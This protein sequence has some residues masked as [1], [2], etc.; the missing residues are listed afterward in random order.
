MEGQ[1]LFGDEIPV[2]LPREE[3]EEEFRSCCEDDEVWKENEEP[4]KVESKDDLD[5]FSV[6]MFFKGISL[7]GFG[8]SS[9]GLSGIGVV[10]ERAANVPVIQVQKKLDFYV[11]EPVADYLALMDGLVEAVQNK[12][13]RVYA[14]TD[15]ELLYDQVSSS[16]RKS[17]VSSVIIWF[18]LSNLKPTAFLI[19][20]LSAT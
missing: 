16:L 3:D 11:E 9:V 15:S 4:V 12:V 5:E 18:L 1:A 7:T 17:Y 10:M 20:Y 2:N 6:K 8:D 13:R 19:F 14:F